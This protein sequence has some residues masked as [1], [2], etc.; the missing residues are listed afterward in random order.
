MET[1]LTF[2]E[3][4]KP[5]QY[6]QYNWNPQPDITA[7]ELAMALPYLFSHNID[8]QALAALPSNVTRH[9]SETKRPNTASSPTAPCAP[10]GD[11]PGDSQRGGLCSGR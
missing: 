1:N 9:F 2:V 4:V 3:F 6:K 5:K 10:A 8:E 11:E 7:W